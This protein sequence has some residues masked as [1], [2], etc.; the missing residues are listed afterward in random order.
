LLE[1]HVTPEREGSDQGSAQEFGMK[2]IGIP[3]VRLARIGGSGD[4][5]HSSRE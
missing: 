3:A 5:R 4:R 1:I 2:K